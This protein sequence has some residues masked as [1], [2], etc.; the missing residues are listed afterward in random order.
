MNNDGN[1]SGKVFKMPTDPRE[2]AVWLRRWIQS[3]F[4]VYLSVTDHV[5]AARPEMKFDQMEKEAD[6]AKIELMNLIKP[7][8]WENEDEPGKDKV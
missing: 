4:K 3:L 8:K 7:E 5:A 1:G 2:K 6:A